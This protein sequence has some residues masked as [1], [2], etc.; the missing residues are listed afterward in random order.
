MILTGKAVKYAEDF[1]LFE[2]ELQKKFPDCKPEELNE[3]EQIELFK[4]IQMFHRDTVF[5]NF[6]CGCCELFNMKALEG[7]EAVNEMLTKFM[8]I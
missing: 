3:D 7:K 8:K 6:M 4:I 5:K 2:K 1:E